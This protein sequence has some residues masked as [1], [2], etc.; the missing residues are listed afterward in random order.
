M[1]EQHAGNFA[2]VF[3]QTAG[4]LASLQGDLAYSLRQLKDA[5]T[6][7]EVDKHHAKI[8]VL[9]GQIAAVEAQR[10]DAALQLQA[11]Q[12]LN[13]NQAAKERQDLLEKQIAEEGQTFTAVGT[14]Q[15][16]LRLTPTSYARP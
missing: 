12:I 5:P 3:S 6:Q 2:T 9:V 8:A 13:D 4:R 7:A 10:R 14:W 1:D 16:S 11:Q 15:E